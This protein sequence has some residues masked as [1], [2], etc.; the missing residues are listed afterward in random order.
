MAGFERVDRFSDEMLREI[1]AIIR[2]DLRDPRIKGVYSVTGV[3]TTRDLSQAR[4]RVSYFGQDEDG[5]DELIAALKGASGFIRRELARRLKARTVPE[6]LFIKDASIA[7][8]AD[9]S[10]K[11]DEAIYGKKEEH[12]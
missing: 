5:H 11:I 9:I 10:K 12:K 1:D 3:E 6:L 8:A 2:S 7:Y 4:V